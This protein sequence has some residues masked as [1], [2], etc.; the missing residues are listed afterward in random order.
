VKIVPPR[1]T[2]HADISE[3]ENAKMREHFGYWSDLTQ[4]RMAI[5]F[6]PV[7]DPAGVFGM[8]VLETET[9]DEAR[10]LA[11]ADPA[12]VAG[13]VRSVIIPMRLGGERNALASA[14]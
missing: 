9:E 6:G 4:K 10:A 13:V 7:F 1:S 2:F 11:A 8:G 3:S 14:P 5:T 12:V